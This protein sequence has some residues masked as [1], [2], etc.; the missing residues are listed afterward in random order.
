M[1]RMSLKCQTNKTTTAAQMIITPKINQKKA[2][3]VNGQV[4]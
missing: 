2:C 3:K 4:T 1:K